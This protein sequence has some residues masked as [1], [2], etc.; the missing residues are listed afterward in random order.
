[1]QKDKKRIIIMTVVLVFTVG[2]LWFVLATDVTDT[3]PLT[4]QF[5]IESGLY[6]EPFYLRIDTS[7]HVRNAHIY[8]TLDGSEPRP[9]FPGT[10]RHD[11]PRR[12]D[13]R[14][15]MANVLSAIPANQIGCFAVYRDDYFTPPHEPVIKATIIRA[16]AFRNGEA[17]SDLI[18]Q[19]YFVRHDI[20]SRY[21]NLPIVSLVTNPDNFF[22]DGIGIY[23]RGHRGLGGYDYGAPLPN[24][25]MRGEEWERPVH[26]EIFE[27]NNESFERAVSQ[28]MGVRIHG[29]G[30]RRLAQKTFRLYA[31]HSYDEDNPTLIH[32]I[33]QG[34]AIDRFGE[35][36]HHFDRLL[37]RNFGNEGTGTMIRDAGLQYL[38]RYLNVVYQAARPTVVFLNGEFWGL[39]DFRERICERHIAA[40][41]GVRSRYVA[42][43]EQSGGAGLNL[44]AGN[45][46]DWRAW[47]DLQTFF[48]DND[49]SVAENYAYAKQHI[50]IDS[51]I[52]AYIANIFF[53]NIDWPGNNVR[54][55]RYNGNVDPTQPGRDGRWRWV[56]FDL[57]STANFGFGLNH[58]EDA[59][60]RVMYWPGERSPMPNDGMA[61]GSHTLMFRRFIRNTEFRAQFLNRFCDLMN[62][63]FAEPAFSEMVDKFSARIRPVV[64]EQIERWGRIRSIDAWEREL[65]NFRNFGRHRQSYMLDFLQ[66]NL[67]LQNRAIVDV[68]LAVNKGRTYINDIA[69]DP[70]ITPGVVDFFHWQGTYFTGT[71]Q[72][73]YAS[74]HSNYSFS[75]FIIEERGRTRES[76]ENPLQINLS[77]NVTVT[78][79]FE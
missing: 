59:L 30:T 67:R 69:L 78:A 51:F 13:D 28:N 32:D 60:Y 55:W 56:L 52:D 34:A 72:T 12:I 38:A 63:Y 73:F 6:T 9:G 50:D 77:D 44:M 33:F 29:G 3:S 42:I 24:W 40:H 48:S 62:T 31:R 57:D 66:A 1:M 68:E 61:Q 18:T 64:P 35:P 23:V 10:Y 8:Y 79:I 49:L 27:H 41:Y 2:I 75:H 76:T 19:S 65:N 37:I 16:Q 74:P 45:E 22:D 5:S 4:L 54:M 14:T 53:G 71:T 20:F 46:S 26:V 47:N 36:I 39:Y 70:A 11:A 58:D 7:R 43:M 25:E 17:I 15:Y 21:D